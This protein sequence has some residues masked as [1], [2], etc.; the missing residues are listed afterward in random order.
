M[1][2]HRL[3]ELRCRDQLERLIHERKHLLEARGDGQGSDPHAK[4]AYLT[5]LDP[6]DTE[7]RASCPESIYHLAEPQALSRQKIPAIESLQLSIRQG[8]DVRLSHVPHVNHWQLNFRK[9]V[10]GVR[11]YG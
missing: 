1:P 2:S 4:L 11:D 6:A 7:L 8:K 10:L 9:A 3:H 5:R